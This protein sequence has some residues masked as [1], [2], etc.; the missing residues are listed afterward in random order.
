MIYLHKYNEIVDHTILKK[1]YVE[2]RIKDNGIIH[3][4]GRWAKHPNTSSMNVIIDGHE[5]A[6]A[7][8]QQYYW[9]GQ[10]HKWAGYII[11]PIEAQ[12]D[13]FFLDQPNEKWKEW[14]DPTPEEITIYNKLK[15]TKRFD[16]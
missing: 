1:M 4:Q 6:T 15:I 13:Y 8:V 14:D 9:S 11:S 12:M 3:I 2:Y 7:I 16:L 5:I 10:R